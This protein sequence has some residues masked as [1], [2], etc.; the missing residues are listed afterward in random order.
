MGH[1]YARI[2]DSWNVS[3]PHN[4]VQRELPN[5][6]EKWAVLFSLEYKST[7]DSVLYPTRVFSPVCE[8]AA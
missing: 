3:R 1:P 6:T 2:L 7:T 8:F 4:V 5:F